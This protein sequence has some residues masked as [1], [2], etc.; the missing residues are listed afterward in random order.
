MFCIVMVYTRAPASDFDD[1][2]IDG[3]ESKNL[4]PLMKK[5]L[6]CVI[7]IIVEL[8]LFFNI[9]GDIRGTTRSSNP[10]V[11][12]THQDFLWRV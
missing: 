12:W 1:W 9:A 4:I 10:R 6:A 7:R 5:V 3:W 11:R 8:K 2:A